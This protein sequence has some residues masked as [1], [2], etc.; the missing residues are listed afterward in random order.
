MIKYRLLDKPKG[1]VVILNKAGVYFG[2]TYEQLLEVEQILKEV[3]PLL[4]KD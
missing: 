4:K 1:T 2:M 3:K